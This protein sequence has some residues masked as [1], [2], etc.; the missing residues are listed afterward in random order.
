[1][2]SQSSTFLIALLLKAAE[3]GKTQNKVLQGNTL[4]KWS[5]V[6]NIPQ[7]HFSYLLSQLLSSANK[8]R[9][10]K[11]CNCYQLLTF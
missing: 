6:K 5:L 4:P 11:S 7:K 1:M 2:A 3:S 8:E 9:V 10:I